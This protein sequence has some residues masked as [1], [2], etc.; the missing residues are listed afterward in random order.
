MAA[1]DALADPVALAR[2]FD[3]ELDQRAGPINRLWEYYRGEAKLLYA[4]V[5][6]RQNF[7]RLLSEIS[8]N[9]CGVVVESA[10]ERLRVSGFRFGADEVA[11]EEAWA[12]WQSSFLDADQV[13]AHEE[14]S[15]SSLCY[16][17]VEPR[18]PDLPRISVLSPLEAITFNDPA[19]HRR[20]IAGYR[21][22]IDEAGIP[23]ARLYLPDRF[24]VLLGKSSGAGGDAPTFGE[25]EVVAEVPNAAGVVPMVEM[26]NKPH[27][28]RGGE[29]DLDPVLSKQ[30][31]INKFLVD[32]VVNSEYSAYH[33]RYATGIEMTTD[34]DGR[35][36]PPQQFLAG[37]SSIFISKNPEAK[38]GAL[39]VSDPGGFVRLIE[40]CVQHLA[41]QTRT[42]PHYLT[43]GLG[44]WPS[45][46]SLR[47]SEEGLVQ[48]CR[49]KILGFGESWEEAMRIAFLFLGDTD[50][51][52]EHSLE[53]IWDNPQRVSL[54]QITD[55]AVK[56]RTSLDVPRRATWQMIGAS[57]QEIEEWETELAEERAAEPEPEPTPTPPGATVPAS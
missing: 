51:G 42:P 46:D 18:D 1:L 49:R 55:A 6:F 56:A 20:R 32:A 22:F 28:G 21:R 48:K 23:E 27:L 54:A 43:A 3:Q 57:P 33:Q 30:D 12:I 41:A 17:L 45:G 2:R 11:D 19:Q 7:G 37:P 34:Q 35:P 9:W 25:W 39:P 31:M 8:D 4:T 44:Q 52:R 14:A 5:K 40:M 24:L 47:A 10:V 53:P 36:V 38:F 15:V 29:S 50:R 16:V 13:L 26:L